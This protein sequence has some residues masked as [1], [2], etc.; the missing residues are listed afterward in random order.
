MPTPSASP[1]A[2]PS[3]TPSGPFGD[4]ELRVGTLVPISVDAPLALAQ[5]AGVEL[6]VR[7]VNEAGGVNGVPVLSFHRDAGDSTGETLR[8]SFDELVE[9][10]VDLI[11]G[12][13]TIE[14]ARQLAPLAAEA[15]VM[16]ISPAITE[17]SAAFIDAGGLFA[18]TIPSAVHDGAGIAAQLPPRARIALIYFSDTTGKGVRD[19]LAAAT[20]RS[21]QALVATIALS[22]DMRNPELILSEL[23]Q[24]DADAIIY[25]GS[26]T[27]QEQN[28]VMLTALGEARLAP[29]LWLTSTVVAGHSVE[30]GILEGAFTVSPGASPDPAF[31]AGLRSGEPR[32]RSLHTAAEAYDAV[33]LAALAA[34]AAGDEGGQ[35]L[36]RAIPDVSADGI[37]CRSYAHC[38]HVLATSGAWGNNIDYEGRSGPLDL[39]GTRSAKP[40]GISV[41]VIDA[42]NTPQPAR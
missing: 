37:P 6:A 4:G 9:L 26:A 14:H 3:A 20:N 38:L 15:G 42:D 19:S 27:R 2:S 18:R 24:A 30:P 1:S 13:S 32:A 25:A 39:D 7:Q 29:S 5:V 22:P 33:I 16:V 8:A 41:R 28:T 34:S 10:G 36:A 12:P 23:R 31:S 21:D 35:A 40:H 11:I 17:P